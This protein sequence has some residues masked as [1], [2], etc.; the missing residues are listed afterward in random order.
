LAFFSEYQ[1]EPL[2]ESAQNQDALTA[3]D[4]MNKINKLLR[5]VVPTA[6]ELLTAYIDVQANV[7]FYVVVAW[8]KDFTGYVVDYGT[9]PEQPQQYFTVARIRK[10]LQ[11]VTGKDSLEGAIYAGLEALV[12]QVCGR[13]YKRQDGT[14]V[15]IKRC[16]IDAAWGAV[17]D[18]V[19][20]FCRLSNHAAVLTPAMGRFVGASSRPLNSTKQA[21]GTTVGLHW[22]LSS[23]GGARSVRYLVYDTN[24]WKSFTAAR[25]RTGFGEAGCLSLYGKEPR[26]HRLFADH[27][28]AEYPVRVESGE[29][30]VDEWKMRPPRRDNH[31]WDCLVGAMVA[32]S[33]EGCEL[34]G[35]RSQSG[36]KQE[37][38]KISFAELQRMRR[39]QRAR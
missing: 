28:T 9:Y 5:Y 36:S 16:L 35:M 22:R 37:R 2:D 25:L 18:L 23:A 39:L 20:E 32:A 8:H 34:P 11:K 26:R 21:P 38:V 17:T 30:V 4:V 13:D 10:T 24:F 27:I 31:Y 29:R 14:L 1:N 7:L 33:L 3:Q 19:F 6:A 15:R 12:D